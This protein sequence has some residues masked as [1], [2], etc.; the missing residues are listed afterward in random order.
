MR[1]IFTHK[2][3]KLVHLQRRHLIIEST[4]ES[5]CKDELVNEASKED[6][7]E[8]KMEHDSK[9]NDVKAYLRA[10]REMLK[11]RQSFPNDV[12]RLLSNGVIHKQ[13]EDDQDNAF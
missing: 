4:S 3:R 8:I 7:D 1:T 6:I 11:N 5:D 9:I 2:Q 13:L 10:R 12:E